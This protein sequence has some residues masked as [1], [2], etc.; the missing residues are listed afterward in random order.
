MIEGVIINPE[1]VDGEECRVWIYVSPLITLI[2]EKS[3]ENFADK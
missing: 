2:Q 1:V 3:S